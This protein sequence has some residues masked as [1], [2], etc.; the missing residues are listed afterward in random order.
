MHWSTHRSIYIQVLTARYQNINLDKQLGA[1]HIQ[2]GE[3]DNKACRQTDTKGGKQDGE[4]RKYRKKTESY[5]T[6][7]E[8]WGKIQHAVGSS[9]ERHIW[10]DGNMRAS[11]PNV[12]CP[13]DSKEG[14]KRN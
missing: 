10:A 2:L 9:Q 6:A 5:P 8:I 14:E 7:W 3:V 4:H 1:K 11:W 13:R 12:R